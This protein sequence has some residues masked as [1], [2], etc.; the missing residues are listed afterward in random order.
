MIA[1]GTRLGPY[2]IEEA[3]GAG[4][5]GEVYRATDTRLDRVVAIKVLPTHLS[6]TP[7]LKERFDREAKTISS[8]QHPHI[9]AL[10]DVG[11]E[12][13]TDFLVMEYLEGQ[14]LAERLKSGPL[15]T[16][17]VLKFGIQV[18]EALQSAHKQGVIHRDLKPGN[19]MVTKAGVKLLDFGL[20][21]TVQK[22][23]SP[24][25]S[26]TELVTEQH[27]SDPLT[28]AGTLLGTFQ[29]MAPEQLE[30]VDADARSDIFALGAVLYEMATGRKAFEGK[31]QA[32]LI[33]SIMSSLP[34]PISEIQA[35]APPA[36]D[37]VIRT[38]LEKDPDNRWQTAHDVALQLKWIEEGG[39]Q[40]GLPKRVLSRRRSRERLGWA[41]AAVAVV[42]AVG[43]LVFGLTRSAPAPARSMRFQIDA[44]PGVQ[45]FG[46]PRV[47]PDGRYIAFN[48][49]DTTGVTRMFVRPMNSLDAYPLPG[50]EACHRPFWS[51]DSRHVGFFASGKLK[52][53]PIGGGPPLTICEF[54]RGSDAVWGSEGTIL[55]DGQG[56]DSIQAVSAG[57]GTASGATRIDREAGETGH[58]WPYFLPD[59]KHFLFIAF[60]ANGPSEI[61]LGTL[62]SFETKLITNGDSRVEFAAPDFLIFERNRT[63]LAQPFDPKAGE[64]TGDAF[65]LT[66]GIGTGVVGLAHFS[67]SL[68][69]T[70]IYTGGDAPERQL[71]W[72][73]RQGD[74]LGIIGSVK[75]QFNPAVSRDGRR[76]AVEV[77]DPQTSKTDIWLID[78]RR[79]AETR[80]TFDAGDDVSPVFS[81][82]GSEVAFGSDRGGDTDV[83]VKNAGGSGSASLMIDTDYVLFPI[84]WS[85]DG[86]TLVGHG[87][88]NITGWDALSWPAAG[89]DSARAEVATTFVDG[90][91]HL[92]PDG[93]YLAYGSNES[94]R[95]EVYLTTF[96][97]GGGKWQISLEGGADPQWRGDGR[98]LYFLSPDRRLMAVEMSL[99]D[100]VEIGVPKELFVAPVPRSMFTRNRYVAAPDG[101]RFLLLTLLDRGRVA[102]ITV[103]LNWTADLAQR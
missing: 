67:S 44:P 21:K 2:S 42:A 95:Y 77:L 52:R 70:L 14:T 6:E 65:P 8:L 75:Q 74:E 37:R 25:S 58:G 76:V 45:S 84:D 48:G 96:P 86:K 63:L 18:T 22:P 29:Y 80:F 88:R 50:T 31:S 26:V 62:G 93:H 17:D 54:N 43:Q 61:R 79:G 94:G 82:D 53:V 33:A 55:F 4:G 72:F 66:E 11:H 38:C 78:V 89:E 83:Y 3:I 1:P 97:S 101:E 85:A 12:D 98:E 60:K 9:C 71:A 35:M 41:I 100:G 15:P 91:P 7:E 64:L 46:S 69:G 20:A 68:E 87:R 47:S 92:S 27:T 57:G 102:P 5:M 36:L 103:I 23:V 19:I 56:G 34:P 99:D 81:P 39:S 51:P 13:G 28:A 30:G 49:I 40:V 73:D 24:T 59:G 32:S 16:E 10:F 90:W